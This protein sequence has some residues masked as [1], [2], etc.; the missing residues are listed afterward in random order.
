MW[1][2][3]LNSIGVWPE[4][5]DDIGNEKESFFGVRR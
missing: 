3:C 1:W 2:K 4:I 5:V